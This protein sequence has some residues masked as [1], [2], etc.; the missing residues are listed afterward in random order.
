MS[1]RAIHDLAVATCQLERGWPRIVEA[2]RLS[3]S[4]LPHTSDKLAELAR[5][6]EAWVNGDP[7]PGES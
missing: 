5:E 1:E 7:P 2:I 3:A 4:Q 6:A